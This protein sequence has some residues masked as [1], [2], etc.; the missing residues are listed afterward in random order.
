[1][2]TGAGTC[3]KGA[4]GGS[5]HQGGLGSVGQGTGII[6]GVAVSGAGEGQGDGGT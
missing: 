2:R 5:F 4:C 3:T 1:M 6:V